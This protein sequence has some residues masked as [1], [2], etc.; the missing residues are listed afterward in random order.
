[1]FD[2]I[3]NLKSRLGFLQKMKIKAYDNE[4]REGKPIG[5]IEVMFNPGSY[6]I[7]YENE[8]NAI[9]GINNP[10]IEQKFE[11]SDN[12][13]LSFTLIFDAS[14]VT[15]KLGIFKDQSIVSS[16]NQFVRLTTE[17]P[18]KK[19]SGP[20]AEPDG[21]SPK[22][23]R[24][25]YLTIE[26]GE[27]VYKGDLHTLDITYTA[28]NP[29]G[30]PIRAELEVS[31]QGQMDK[32]EDASDGSGDTASRITKSKIGDGITSLCNAM[33]N[34]PLLYIGVSQINRLKHFRSIKAGLNLLFPSL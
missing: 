26:W 28:F 23:S 12:E 30:T 6:T 2:D 16:I 24:P 20:N 4:D 10:E 14:N 3:S 18:S 29:D 21:K 34:N 8:F 1:M 31:F 11:T 5:Q 33:Y 19:D 13:V 32:P 7:S 27:M 9:E 15:G 17:V 25:Y 22:L